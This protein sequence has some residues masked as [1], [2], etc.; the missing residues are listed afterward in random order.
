MTLTRQTPRIVRG[1]AAAATVAL[2]ATISPSIKAQSSV[3]VLAS[4][5]DNPRGL[6]FGPDGAL[7]VAEA[8]RGGNSTLCAPAPD[9]PLPN[10]CYG[11]SGA[12]TRILAQVGQTFDRVVIDT[13]PVTMIG[14][15]LY[16]VPHA[17]AVCLVVQAGKTP[18]QAV[19]RACLL[20]G[21]PPTGLVLNQVRPSRR[22]GYY[23]Y[24]E[25]SGTKV[26]AP[27]GAKG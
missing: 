2:V 20:L 24:A 14:D 3:L 26:A 17:T 9:P 1:I 4:G 25:G 21:K 7:Y 27:V 18:R 10:R 19:R 23:Y 16:V 8:G 6:N 13:A 12:I 11:P 5:L 15:A 22:S